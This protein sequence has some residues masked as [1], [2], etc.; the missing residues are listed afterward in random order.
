MNI[1][2]EEEENLELPIVPMIDCAFLLLIFFLI[3]TTMKKPDQDAQQASVYTVALPTAEAPRSIPVEDAKRIIVTADGIVAPASGPDRE[4]RYDSMGALVDEL[5]AYRE[6]CAERQ[7]E[8][9][10]IVAGDKDASFQRVV[11]VWN[12]VRTAGIAQVSFAIQAGPV[13]TR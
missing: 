11:H 13:A 5:K 12:A 9:V 3:A 7:S 6:R 10:V 2:L 8:P 1:Q 4:A